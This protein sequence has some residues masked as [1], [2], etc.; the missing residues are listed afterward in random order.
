M[1]KESKEPRAKS[2]ER[3]V[4]AAVQ[5]RRRGR[6]PA[7][8]IAGFT[9][10]ELLVVIT[11]IG[12]LVGLMLPAVQAAREAGRRMQCSNNL[13]QIGLAF[14]SHLQAKNAFPGGGS[15]VVM[16]TPRTW[17]GDQVAVYDQQAWSWGY[18]ILPYIEETALWNNRDDDLVA[19][20]P[21]PGYFCPTRRRPVA[22]A[23]GPWQVSAKPRAMIDYAGNAGTSSTG[24]AMGSAFASDGNDGAICRLT[25]AS[26]ARAYVS[27][28]DIAD[29]L[30]TTIMVG[31]KNLNSMF[32]ASQCQPDDNVGYVGPFE[33]DVARWGGCGT[34]DS[35]SNPPGNFVGPMFPPAMDRR[36]DTE[37]AA[38]IKATGRN[39]WFGSSHA[40]GAQF[41]FCDGSVTLIRFLVDPVVFVRACSRNDHLTFDP[42]TL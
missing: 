6:R 29:G 14:S 9:L 27:A 42:S 24:G 12:I 26:G 20:T 1:W 8:N 13:K 25:D 40:S 3:T 10:V 18:Q 39:F 28:S 7:P 35:A 33:D 32:S 30:S 2:K 41:V 16:P 23:A 38:S 22:L 15:A 19:R 17:V 21:L 37:T 34:F 11:I 36:G 4:V 5:P 31:E